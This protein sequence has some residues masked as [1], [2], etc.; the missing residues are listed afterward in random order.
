MSDSFNTC[1]SRAEAI[2]L[3]AAGCLEG[4][5]Q[6]E[7]SRH[8]EQCPACRKQLEQ[9]AELCGRL[10]EARPP[11]GNRQTPLV[12]G[13]PSASRI[14]RKYASLRGIAL[15]AAPLA[16]MLALAVF[17]MLQ[18]ARPWFLDPPP[19]KNQSR[20]IPKEA[21]IADSVPPPIPAIDHANDHASDLANDLPSPTLLQ[22]RQAAATSEEAFD[23]LLAASNAAPLCESPSSFSRWQELSP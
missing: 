16:A 2:S 12:V 22:L 3:L 7:L 8:L 13:T 19:E 20:A 21:S 23:V 18:F 9:T 11:L 17:V 1:E 14:E 10:R 15:A 6:L 5:E 4:P